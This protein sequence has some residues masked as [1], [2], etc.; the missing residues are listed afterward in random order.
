MFHSTLDLQPEPEAR[1]LRQMPLVLCACIL[2]C[3]HPGPPRKA[4]QEPASAP[5][6][7]TSG[8][9]RSVSPLV[10]VRPSQAEVW[11]EGQT[12]TIRW[13]A[14]SVDRVNVAVALGG[15]DKGHLAFGIAASRDSLE[16]Q[17][18][19]GFVSGFGIARSDN[20]RVRIEDADNPARYAD[21]SPFTIM[22]SASN[23]RASPPVRPPRNV[24]GR[25]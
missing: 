17:I 18:P 23:R 14:A 13:R 25:P 2:A 24:L 21:S 11:R 22:A 16:W 6:I 4:A 1:R 5:D 8:I 9:G 15:K 19:S 3:D 12:Y 20:V 7:E 10:I